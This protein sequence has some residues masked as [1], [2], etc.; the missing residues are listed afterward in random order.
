MFKICLIDKL[1]TRI[2]RTRVQNMS[3]LGPPRLYQKHLP[4]PPPQDFRFRDVLLTKTDDFFLIKITS[5]KL[6]NFGPVLGWVSCVPKRVFN[7]PETR[8]STLQHNKQARRV[9]SQRRSVH[10]CVFFLKWPPNY[11]NNIDF[12]HQK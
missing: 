9:C 8:I 5:P 10:F 1:E 3:R 7:K 6:A 11:A 4:K 2:S 12:H